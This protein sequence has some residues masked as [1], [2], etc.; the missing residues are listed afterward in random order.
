MQ[1]RKKEKE[2]KERKEKRN[3]KSKNSTRSDGV[4]MNS[5]QDKHLERKGK[6]EN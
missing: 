4:L 6:K 5:E 3:R 2:E 1:P